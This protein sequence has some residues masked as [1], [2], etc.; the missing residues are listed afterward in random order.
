MPA[1]VSELSI[2]SRYEVFE[3]L[4][5]GSMGVVYRVFDRLT[6]QNVALK[7]VTAPTDRLIFGSL[8]TDTSPHLAMARE[9]R[10]LA[11]LRHPNIISVLD[12]GFDQ[13]QQPY[14]T[15]NLMEGSVPITEAARN[16]P[17][18]GRIA[19][20]IQ[21]L[22]ALR[23]L[24]RNGIIH[25]DLKPS[26]VLVIDQQV[27]ILDFGLS[28]KR[29]DAEKSD[30]AGTIAYM[31]P[32]VLIGSPATEASDL[33]A[34][35]IMGYEMLTG[36]HPFSAR[37]PTAIMT[38]ILSDPINLSLLND[39][40]ILTPVI[41]RL[42][43]KNPRE[44]YQDASEVAI[45]LSNA[46]NLPM[47]SESSAIR[48]SFLQ[49]AK[50]IGREREME[51]LSALLKQ[52][53]DGMGSSILIGGESGVGKSRLLEELRIRALVYGLQ[54]VRGQE[55]SDGSSPYQLWRNVLRRLILSIRL[56]PL[57]AMVL[58][59]LIPDIGKLLRV[60]VPDAPELEAQAAQER[61]LSTIENV[62]RQQKQ[63]TLVILED[64]HWISDESRAALI[65]MSRLVDHVHLIIVSSYRDDERAD[66]PDH[67]PGIQVIK[68]MRLNEESIAQ[69]SES[70]LGQSG[71]KPNVVDFLQR[72]TEGNVFFLVEVV[73]A[74][75]EEA[76]QLDKVGDMT[77]PAS[78]FAGG[79]TEVIRR[80]LN[81]VS[82]QEQIY[83]QSAAVIG[84][85]LNEKLLMSAYPDLDY[86]GW[87]TTCAHAAILEVQDNRWRFAH[88]K[89]REFLLT[90]MQGE[91]RRAL[92]QQTAEAITTVYG[93]ANDQIPALAYH[94]SQAQVA[95]K[96]VY[97]L[98]KAAQGAIL[99]GA[100]E[101]AIRLVNQ[102]N[103]LD[104]QNPPP[105]R[106]ARRFWIL[107]DAYFGLGKLDES[108]DNLEQA[109]ALF[110]FPI[111]SQTPRVAAALL[112]E[113]VRQIFHRRWP[114]H[115]LGRSKQSRE[116]LA[117]AC[118]AFGTLSGVYFI[119]GNFLLW[120]YI[121]VL[122]LN[123][124][125]SG[126]DAPGLKSLASLGYSLMSVLTGTLPLHGVATSYRD[127]ALVD[128]EQITEPIPQASVYYM[129][130]LYTLATAEWGSAHNLTEKARELYLRI[131]STRRWE[132]TTGLIAWAHYYQGHFAQTNSAWQKVQDQATRRRDEH[133]RAWGL[134][135]Q[136]MDAVRAGDQP[137]ETTSASLN[138]VQII[139]EKAEFSDQILD[140]TYR[141][142]TGIQ[143][144]RSQQASSAWEVAE[145][146][147]LALKKNPPRV[148]FAM[149]IY[150]R[151]AEIYLTLWEAQETP[152]V[153]QE[154]SAQQRAQLPK[155]AQQVCKLLRSY[156][157]AVS[158]AKPRSWLW[159]GVYEHLSN[160]AKP[161]TAAWSKSLQMAQAMEMPYDEG[162]AYYYMGQ[163]LPQGDPQ[164][165]SL[166]DQA[167]SHFERLDAIYDLAR[168][169]T[170]L[171]T[172][173]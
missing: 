94:W 144:L 33:Y 51:Q 120:A 12:F 62:F 3:R 131:G 68:L 41:G 172:S 162:L 88:D 67:L 93:E 165:Q 25:R 148:A 106:L 153:G 7:S 159:Q 96:A 43:T 66:L 5:A 26:N 74:L 86:E 109:S 80:R 164:R 140:T 24:H 42:L 60:D 1:V 55:L 10:T 127:M 11:S 4:G 118:Y 158:F 57:D 54:V 169:R 69:L 163:S 58:K 150:D 70:I 32:E 152:A 53:G 73:R 126:Q 76:G 104:I 149:E 85:D 82:Q 8:Q 157:N 170:A 39:F 35:G 129:T 89:L 38:A 116:M 44:R 101:E 141:I 105:L 103:T 90:E 125:E 119:Q 15:M 113:I 47:E 102:A 110:G 78:I 132:E 143:H 135:G 114:S 61:L 87:L 171:N 142:L 145:A 16:L 18:T 133:S 147:R 48:E 9:F 56:E 29:E 22:Q 14:F 122:G 100:A 49:A 72:E 79:V 168:V 98:D 71:R 13:Q 160:R 139:L 99:S 173:H 121:T 117:Q 40:P 155:A 112:G 52:A 20:L 136:I 65:H 137:L 21:M 83:L 97:Y 63:P 46:A 151:L 134:V 154:L 91:R 115:F 128:A 92:H 77:L 156:S 108:A 34:V 95:D 31:S 138:E 27:K 84:R 124:A 81:R 107:G 161:A 30:T 146:V 17:P 123:V 19:L 75:A 64:L 50:F 36:R 59:A 45:V 130:G 166:L 37:N 28:I 167:V 23:Y 6:D 111:R 2:D